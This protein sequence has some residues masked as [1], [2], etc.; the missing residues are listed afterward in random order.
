MESHSRIARIFLLPMPKILSVNNY[1]YRRGGSD[2]VYLSHAGLMESL[3]WQNGYFA[4]HHPKNLPTPWSEYFVDEIE[5]GEQYPI[6]R[7]IGMA[8]KSIYSF[9]AQRK[10][11][12]LLRAFK[13]DVA[14][15]H[16]IYHHLS[17]SILPT[18]SAAGVPVVMTAHDLKIA[19]PAYKMLNRSGIC[20]RCKGG[21]LTNVIRHRCIRD[22]LAASAIVAVESAL[23]RAMKAYE[24][25]LNRIIVPSR[26]F[27]QKFIEWGLSAEKFVYI[28][29]YINASEY[30][31]SYR[32]GDYFLYFGRLAP[33]KGVGTLLQASRAAGVAL[34]VVG[35]GPEEKALLELRERIGSGAEFLGFKSGQELHALV[36]GA[37]AVVLPSEW[38]ENAPISVLE[39]FALG[40]PVI[41]ARIG[42]I[43]ELIDENENGWTFESGS[44]ADLTALIT[45]VA[46]TSNPDIEAMGRVARTR[47]EREFSRDQYIESIL[48]L[49]GRLGVAG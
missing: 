39:S 4:M 36:R 18:L 33:E 3:G 7:K 19:C 38:Y 15:L 24:K 2:A 17:P 23:Q 49:Y 8:V 35:T 47:V 27:R 13:P 41:G 42:G 46:Q 21:S 5:F 48:G 6:H 28:P 34:K 12:G 44:V 9:E 10:L 26:F 29:N 16:C 45:R 20:E 11:S 25:Y 43:P 31:P 30:E 40:K 1:H 37:R 14:H 22:S 32:A